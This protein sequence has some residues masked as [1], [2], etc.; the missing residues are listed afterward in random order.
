MVQLANYVK[1][2]KVWQYE[3]SY[4]RLDGK[5][6]KMRKSGFR[7]KGD[8]VFAATE[9]EN[10]ILKG[11]HPD[12]KNEL[13]SDYFESW[14][15]V[16]K[17]NAVGDRTYRRYEDTL[18]N[19][20]K[21]AKNVTLGD[22]NKTKYQQ[23]LNDYAENHAKATV[24]RLHTHIRASMLT[25]LDE[26]IIFNDATRAPVL[27]GGKESKKAS[28]K[29]LNYD[30]F[31]RLIKAV[32][33]RLDVRY[34]SPYLILVGGVT[35]ARFAELLGLT[36]DC[37]DLDN[38]EIR[39]DKT[40]INGKGFSPTK[41]ESSIRTID[42]DKKT[43]EL[44]LDYQQSQQEYL[45]DIK[46]NNKNNLVFFN[47]EEQISSAA[48]N[49]T[50]RKVQQQLDINPPITFHGLRHTYASILL[51][52]EIDI[53]TVSQLLGH[54]DTSITQTTYAHVVEELR[55]KNKK[56]VGNLLANIYDA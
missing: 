41:N 54:K 13:L 12:R 17:K 37:V 51:Y 52:R 24:K 38:L 15:K 30:D 2:G 28:E 42:I 22:L 46:T 31:K 8:A 10:E 33:D 3:I 23:I 47:G 16:F 1:R 19:L 9:I 21:Y 7:T 35:G 32:N 53:F 48:V 44:L 50:L 26:K 34:T 6:D 18:S 39:I 29:Y 27:K 40:W 45:K 56:R 43:A 25:A 55:Q 11:Y 14:M 49:K 4:K 5:F 36:W 20:K